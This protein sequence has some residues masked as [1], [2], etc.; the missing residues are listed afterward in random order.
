MCSNK[1]RILRLLGYT[2]FLLIV[3]CCPAWAVRFEKVSKGIL[4]YDLSQYP[5]N[6]IGSSFYNKKG[7]AEIQHNIRM[8]LYE[9]KYLCINSK[10]D[11]LYFIEEQPDYCQECLFCEIWNGK[12]GACY[13]LRGNEYILLNI[14]ERENQI[15]YDQFVCLND[16]ALLDIVE[17]WDTI[18][19]REN[20]C[21]VLG[22]SYMRIRRLI[23]SR[24]KCILDEMYLPGL[25]NWDVIYEEP[26]LR[27]RRK[28][29]K[30]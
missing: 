30:Q 5:E 14:T 11:T 17:K 20:S 28:R 1:E 25:C 27:E 3:S 6:S 19:M 4:K 12:S 10:T 2:M 21:E 15:F 8:T 22:T 18:R 24:G 23:I 7:R 29:Y 26:T 16:Y 13:E 9:Q